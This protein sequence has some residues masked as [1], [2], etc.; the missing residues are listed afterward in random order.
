MRPLN[1]TAEKVVSL[2]TKARALIALPENWTQGVRSRSKHGNW[3]PSTSESAAQ[4]CAI[5]AMDRIVDLEFS[6]DK[7]LRAD[8]YYALV[9]AA[10]VAF[11]PKFNDTST[12]KQVLAAFDKAIA[13]HL[14]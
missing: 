7:L 3:C 10:G 4:W 11:F 8:A 2:L 14:Q 6:G 12:H 5:G 1:T 9:D 13:N